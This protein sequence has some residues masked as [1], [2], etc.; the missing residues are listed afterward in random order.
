MSDAEKK[1][2][3]KM[4]FANGSLEKVFDRTYVSGRLASG[5]YT[6]LRDYI[7][8]NNINDP[9][10]FNLA[11]ES[12]YSNWSTARKVAPGE[13][14]PKQVSTFRTAVS[15]LRTALNLGVS[16]TDANGDLRGKSALAAA[17]KAK[18]EETP[19]VITDDLHNKRYK[20]LQENLTAMLVD[21]DPVT[22]L[23]YVKELSKLCIDLE[24]RITGVKN[25]S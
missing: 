14:S 10:S 25:A 22:Q 13:Q 17:N 11:I 8:N 16:L 12:A 18:K 15:T 4:E 2:E 6:D 1:N 7:D 23:K 21:M 24:N 5:I 9:E 19:V 3:I 20:K